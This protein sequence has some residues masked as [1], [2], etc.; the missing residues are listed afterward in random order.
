MNIG[1]D[2]DGVLTDL[3]R[4]SIDYG[5]K[6][7]VEEGIETQINTEKYWEQEK[8]NWTEEQEEKFWNKYLEEYVTELKPREF[9]TEVI[10]KLQQRGDKIY[11]ITARNESGLPPQ[12]YGKMQQMTKQ[13]LEKNNIKYEK[14]IFTTDKEKLQK[15]LENNI[16]IMIED[17][18]KNIQSISSQIP[19][20]KF[21]CLYNKNIQGKVIVTAYSWYHVF[22]IIEKR[23]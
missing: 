8:F 14:L 17:S 22:E 7:N 1:I 13:W 12:S 3:E 16:D 21:E 15:C 9:A 11:I 6:F 5:A 20:I 10:Q 19:V 2:I 23:R 4:F 18:P